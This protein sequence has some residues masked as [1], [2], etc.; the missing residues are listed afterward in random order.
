MGFKKI[1][2]LVTF[3]VKYL[4]IMG[5]LSDIKRLLWVN[6][7][8]AESAAD[9]AVEKGRE[10][11]GDLANKVSD[12]W[13][14]GMDKAGE[15]TDKV[16]TKTQET[17]KDVKEKASD[18]WDKKDDWIQKDPPSEKTEESDAFKTGEKLG[19]TAG[20]TW[21]KAKEQGKVVLD[22]A[23]ETSDKIWE[24]ASATGEDLW[25]KAKVAANKAGDKFNEGVDSMLEKAK[26]LDKKI[27][28]EK[29]KID[30]NRDGWADTPINEK[31]KDSST[32][33]GKDDF[34]E[35]ADR[36]ASGDYAM[37]KP[38][39]VKP[40]KDD[41]ETTDE[42]MTPLPPLPKHD[43]TVDDA[44]LDDGDEKK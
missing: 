17:Y 19:E 2:F 43:N 39:V 3:S 31:L 20:K 16:V 25:E 26:D 33:K 23:V 24:K 21:D 30:P 27:Q 1:T 38:V 6:K 35:K 5:I 10:I 11:G 18:L 36:Y 42:G 41:P 9:K 22:K 32:L 8:V 40:T 12:T 37:G 15:L 7:A 44:I 4:A 13:D 34:F 14:K 28:D 29:D